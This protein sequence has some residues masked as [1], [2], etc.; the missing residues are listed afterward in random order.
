MYF[1]VADVTDPLGDVMRFISSFEVK[2]GSAHP[3][4]YQ[5]TYSQVHD[6]N[7]FLHDSQSS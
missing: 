2:Y 6:T 3:V 1:D 5:G 7:S 4:F